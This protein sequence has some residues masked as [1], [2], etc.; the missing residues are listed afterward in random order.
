MDGAVCNIQS[1]QSNVDYSNEL[2]G[3]VVVAAGS[4][5]DETESNFCFN[6]LL[7]K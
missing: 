6:K 7:T 3:F 5:V 4:I 2:Q 1:F